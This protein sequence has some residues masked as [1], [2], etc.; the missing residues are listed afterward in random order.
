M[1]LTV[2]FSFPECVGGSME[3][4]DSDLSTNYQTYCDPRLNYEQSLD[5]AFLIAQYY[6][7]ERSL[8]N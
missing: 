3:L 1:V 6:E 2:L 8:Q 5:V 7:K 4:K